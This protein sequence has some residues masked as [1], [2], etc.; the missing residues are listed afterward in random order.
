[1]YKNNKGFSLVEISMVLI[2]I[3]VIVAM[4][5]KAYNI[6]NV[7]KI[8]GELSKVSK[9][10]EAINTYYNVFGSLPGDSLMDPKG[11]IYEGTPDVASTLVRADLLEAT[12]M[13]LTRHR[14]RADEIGGIWRFMRCLEKAD[15][16][17]L[18]VNNHNVGTTA[19][20]LAGHICVT[21]DN[22]TANVGN[23]AVYAN[24]TIAAQIPWNVVAGYELYYD[25]VNMVAGLGRANN[26]DNQ[27]RK[28]L[29]GRINDINTYSY[30]YYIKV[31]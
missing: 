2:I 8:R 10:T 5:V 3:G 12:D 19:E 4:S 25:D 22:K 7:A 17:Y 15:G 21:I 20:P 24:S 14:I 26:T 23:A 6:V 28:A 31:W 27:T 18:R 9:I 16:T 13:I 1:M 11:I 29:M 30:E